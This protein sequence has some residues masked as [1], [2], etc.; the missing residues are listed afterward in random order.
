VIVEELQ[1]G[2]QKFLRESLE[3]VGALQRHVGLTFS[4]MEE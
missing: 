1:D 2:E 3:T 4:G